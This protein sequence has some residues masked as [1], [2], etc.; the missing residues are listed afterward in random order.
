MRVNPVEW[1]LCF[2]NNIP[3]T[4][5]YVPGHVGDYK[6]IRAYVHDGCFAYRNGLISEVLSPIWENVS[7]YKP[8]RPINWDD[9]AHIEYIIGDIDIELSEVLDPP[10]GKW[11]LYTRL[12]ARLPVSCKYIMKGYPDK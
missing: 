10:L 3:D 11:W 9:V 2:G 8:T 6:I 7:Y 12:P 4:I 5:T 1:L